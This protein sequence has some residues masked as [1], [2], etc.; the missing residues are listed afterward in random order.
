MNAADDKPEPCPKCDGKGYQYFP[1]ARD[2]RIAA[3]YACQE[4]KGTDKKSEPKP[5]WLIK[6]EAGK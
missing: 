6:P 4:C 2:P 5:A 1:S 3:T